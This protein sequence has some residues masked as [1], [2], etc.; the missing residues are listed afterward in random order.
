MK[1]QPKILCLITLLCIFENFWS[2]FKPLS[3]SFWSFCIYIINT[4]SGVTDVPG[5]FLFYFLQILFIIFRRRNGREKERERN[6]NIRNTGMCLAN[7]PVLGLNLR[8]RHVPWLG[9]ELLT[10]CFVG[11]Y[12]TNWAT[13]VRGGVIFRSLFWSLIIVCS[14][15]QVAL[16]ISLEFWK[17]WKIRPLSL[18][19]SKLLGF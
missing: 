2:Y 17:I 10:L 6:I 8:L 3:I 15:C 7:C 4:H 14:L 19:K 13:P 11:Q 9:I 1:N 18:P 5:I 12:P 16:K